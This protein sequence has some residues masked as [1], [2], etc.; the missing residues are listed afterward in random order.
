[1]PM[2]KQ[3]CDNCGI[4]HTSIMCFFKPRK[5]LAN[6]KAINRIGKVGAENQE[7][8]RAWI[9][10]NPPPYQ[11]YL[12]ISPDCLRYLDIDTVTLEHVIPK[13]RGRQ[14]ARDFS[15]IRPACYA[16]NSLKGSRS[17]ESL[18]LT[19]PHLSVYL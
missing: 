15:N 19:Y 6:K 13:S 16:C 7:I 1:M 3:Y 17:L 5:P 12:V 10:L 4:T 8:R 9:Q 11:C 2:S 18:S 14:Y